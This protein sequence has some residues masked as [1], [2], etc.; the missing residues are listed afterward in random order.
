[1]LSV[2]INLYSI[3]ADSRELDKVSGVLPIN[4][5]P[6][7]V[8]PTELVNCLNPVFDIAYD[9]SY[10]SANY[11]YCDTFDRYYYLSAPH[12]N[13]AGRLELACSIDIRQSFKTA[14]MNTYCTI[15]RTSVYN[16]PTLYT[17]SKLPVYP[18]EKI[19]TSIEL[20][21]VNNEL[22]TDGSWCYLLTVMGS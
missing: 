17:D 22:D 20:P 8:E 6:I 9:A 3:A 1:M 14:I 16:K 19:V 18:N 12:L 2:N 11:L 10:L 13:T 15:L 4:T 7:P 21:E 5:L